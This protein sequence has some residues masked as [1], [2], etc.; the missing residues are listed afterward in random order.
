[1]SRTDVQVV[2]DGAALADVAAA[3]IERVLQGASEATPATVALAGGH[4][5]R[6]TYQHLAARPARWRHVEFFFGDERCVPPDDDGSNYLMAHQALFARVPLTADQ[7][8][9]IPGELEPEQAA[10]AAEEDLRRAFPGDGPP[11]LDLILLGLGPEGHTAS[12]FPEAP[13]LEITDRLMVPVNRPDLPQPWRVSMTLPVLNAAK[14][15]MF[16]VDGAEKAPVVARAIAGDDALPAG[17]IRPAGDLTW[18]VT[19]AAAADLDSTG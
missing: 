10:F 15:V 18:L 4:T 17:R 1:M 16:L 3:H 7:V 9:R 13:E 11:A 5:P 6:A 2:S 8:H 19:E 12:L 14:H